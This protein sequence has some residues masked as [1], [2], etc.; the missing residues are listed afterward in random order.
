M[1]LWIQRCRDKGKK[2]QTAELSQDSQQGHIIAPNVQ[3]QKKKYNQL[4]ND[5]CSNGQNA[6]S[7]TGYMRIRKKM[8]IFHTFIWSTK[9]VTSSDLFTFFNGFQQA[10]SIQA[11]SAYRGDLSQTLIKCLIHSSHPL[12]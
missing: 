12:I 2:I 11:E 3:I 4:Q 9:E 6:P 7:L 5:V 1:E 10:T 8:V